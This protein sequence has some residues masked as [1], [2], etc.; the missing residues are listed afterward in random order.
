MKGVD[1]DDSSRS[2]VGLH[3]TEDDL[4]T[5]EDD[6]DILEDD[7]NWLFPSNQRQG[8]SESI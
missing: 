5:T 6:L 7:Q 2:Q 3:T 8:Q 4:Q 1:T